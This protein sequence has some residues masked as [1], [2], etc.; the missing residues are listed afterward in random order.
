M[1]RCAGYVALFMTCVALSSL[2][3]LTNTPGASERFR[4][5]EKHPFQIRASRFML[6]GRPVRIVS[7]ECATH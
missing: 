4:N 7:C 2:R 3:F 5:D 1:Q 6:Y